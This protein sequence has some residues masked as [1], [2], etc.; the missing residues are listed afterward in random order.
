MLIW[1]RI[2]HNIL[3]AKCHSVK[4]FDFSCTLTGMYSCVL[5]G[6]EPYLTGCSHSRTLE[7]TF[8]NLLD[9]FGYTHVYLCL[10]KLNLFT[11]RLAAGNTMAFSLIALAGLSAGESHLS[12]RD[13]PDI[14]QDAKNIQEL[15][16]TIIKSA[17]CIFLPFQLV[18][19]SVS[20]A[21]SDSFAT[22]STPNRRRKKQVIYHPVVG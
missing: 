10:T 11:V 13:A 22:S 16:R 17:F 14:C 8:G 5:K 7:F 4:A 18:Y 12:W 19:N 21:P 6:R 3:A 2:E 15:S 1:V 9:T 20:R